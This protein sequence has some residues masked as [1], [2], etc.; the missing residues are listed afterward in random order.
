MRIQI[1]GSTGTG[2]CSTATSERST[3]ATT[4][5]YGT[6]A[7]AVRWVENKD[8]TMMMKNHG[9]A[10]RLSYLI[11]GTQYSNWSLTGL[12]VLRNSL[13]VDHI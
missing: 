1:Y 11:L 3:N 12:D 13:K 7:T 2:R 10:A 9:F 5:E 4:A 8:Q 6:N